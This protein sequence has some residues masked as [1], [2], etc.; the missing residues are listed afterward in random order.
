MYQ[1]D[2][3]SNAFAEAFPRDDVKFRRH[4]AELLRDTEAD[5]KPLPL[6]NG[7]ELTCRQFIH[8]NHRR[9]IVAAFA[10]PAA[11][12]DVKAFIAAA[13]DALTCYYAENI[14][15]VQPDN[16]ILITVT[17]NAL[18]QYTVAQILFGLYEGELNAQ[19]ARTLIVHDPNRTPSCRVL[20]SVVPTTRNSLR[21]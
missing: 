15:A 20:G 4:L 21:A 11:T 9:E 2:D 16:L 5:Q 19:Q 17:R 18:G 12:T 13:L 14:L 10:Q 1:N 3:I 7:A 6:A 8:T